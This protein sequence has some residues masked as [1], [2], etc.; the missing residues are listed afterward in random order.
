MA[1]GRVVYGLR[2]LMKNFLERGAVTHSHLR[3]PVKPRL[4]TLDTQGQLVAARLGP[5][6]V[7]GDEGLE[8]HRRSDVSCF[9]NRRD[10]RDGTSEAPRQDR[11][12]AESAVHLKPSKLIMDL[13]L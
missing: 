2:G 5:T 7:L 1:V 8:Q 4:E 6:L 9:N 10:N 12:L 11:A 3:L 13:Y